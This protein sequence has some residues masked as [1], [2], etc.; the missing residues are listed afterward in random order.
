V[1]APFAG[2]RP[3]RVFDR[4]VF[5]LAAPRSGSTLLFDLLERHPDL[6][7]WPF[8]AHSAFTAAQ[9]DGH[10]PALGHRWPPSYATEE[11]RRDLSRE[12]YLGGIAARRRHGLPVGR[13]EP[14]AIRKIRL[15]E[16]TP[17]NVLRIG[18]LA[19]LYP[20]AR[21]V[22][23]HRDAPGSIASLIEAWETP[24]AA[25]ATLVV[26]GREVSWMMLAAPGWLDMLDAPV[27]ERAAFQWRA[28]TAWALADLAEVSPERVLRLSYEDLVADPVA[29]LRRVLDHCRLAPDPAV[30]A[31]ADRVGSA[32]RTSFSAPDPDKW[33]GRAADVEPLLPSL[34]DLRRQLGYAP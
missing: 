34:A 27:P 15:L 7:S 21:L 13:L 33:R 2:R 20:D 30:L 16:K 22:Y 19:R 12:L 6:V 18:A 8:E 31:G 4:P 11:V 26:D 28:G 14:L 32:G 1:R 24:S 23:L 29:Q 10:D 3:W 25:H 5:V 9:P 17:A